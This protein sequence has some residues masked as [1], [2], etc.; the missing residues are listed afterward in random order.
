MALQAAKGDES[1]ADSRSAAAPLAGLL[2]DHKCFRAT[3]VSKRS[4]DR[5]GAVVR[6]SGPGTWVTE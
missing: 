2:R 5:E 4:R 3:H 6:G 1:S